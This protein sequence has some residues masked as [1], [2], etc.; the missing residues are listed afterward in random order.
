MPSED[1]GSLGKNAPDGFMDVFEVVVH[2]NKYSTPLKRGQEE[3]R[4]ILIVTNGQAGIPNS[5]PQKFVEREL[6]SPN[7]RQKRTARISPSFE[8]FPA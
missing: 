6:A 2:S 8:V 7:N 3:I 1:F 4:V 5:G